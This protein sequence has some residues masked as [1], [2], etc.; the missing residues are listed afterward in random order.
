MPDE[1]KVSLFRKGG[2][3]VFYMQYRDPINGNKVSRTTGTAKRRDAERIAGQWEKDL[4]SGADKR[5][6]RMTWDEFRRQYED[7]V[8]ASLAESTGTKVAGVFNA[9]EAVIKPSRLGDLTPNRISALAKSFRDDG[10]SE[11]TIKGKLAHLH[12]ALVWGVDQGYLAAVPKFP[13]IQRAKGTR[14][15]KGR[16]ITGEEFDR[17]LAN[18]EAGIVN[19]TEVY[20]HKRKTPAKRISQ[21]ARDAYRKRQEAVA[22]RIAPSWQFF[23]RGLWCSG[24]RLSEALDLHWTDPDRLHVDMSCRHPMLR[25][26]A[27]A[28]KG[29]KDRLLP[30]APE[31]AQMLEEVPAEKRKGFVFNPLPLLAKYA[32]DRL[33]EQQVG[34][35]ITSIG[36]TARIVVNEKAGK[37]KYASAHD[38]RRSFG[39]RWAARVMPQ[40]LMELMRHETI[41]TTLRYY[42]GRNA[43]QTAGILWEAARS[44][45]GATLGATPTPAEAETACFPRES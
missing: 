42:V 34:R 15:M 3:S 23:L 12:A 18:A 27:E 4:R 28:E 21:E 20:R 26:P 16:P 35:V 44:A 19:V 8:L 13:K 7:D 39:D 41:E 30:M 29:N 43:Q 9:V 25:I 6:G 36:K 14:V 22:A 38:L 31:F 1:I 2:R 37:P 5:F 24:L 45:V 17:M 33:G 40:V 10:R 32:G 11:T